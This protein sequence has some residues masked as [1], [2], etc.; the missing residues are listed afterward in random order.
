MGFNQPLVSLVLALRDE[1]C[2]INVQHRH[3]ILETNI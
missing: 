1:E 2:G 3:C